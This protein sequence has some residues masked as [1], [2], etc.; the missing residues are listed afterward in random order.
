MIYFILKKYFNF[1]IKDYGFYI[2]FKQKMGYIQLCYENSQI[3]IMISGQENIH[4]LISD[5]NSLGTYAD[6]TEYCDE[7][8]TNGNYHQKA[9]KAS[10]WL[11]EKIN[12]YYCF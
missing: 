7:F 9:R 11:K 6:V 4:I 12:E 5:V 8:K 10:Q 3:R 1:L 2:A